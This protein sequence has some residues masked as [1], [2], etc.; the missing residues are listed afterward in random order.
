MIAL[1][2]YI[3]ISLIREGLHTT[4]RNRQVVVPEVEGRLSILRIRLDCLVFNRVL[5]VLCRARR[6]RRFQCRGNGIDKSNGGDP[7]ET[8]DNRRCSKRTFAAAVQLVPIPG[9]AIQVGRFVNIHNPGQNGNKHGSVQDS[10][11]YAETNRGQHNQAGYDS[12]TH[13][14][15]IAHAKDR[16]QECGNNRAGRNDTAM[17]SA[18]NIMTT[19]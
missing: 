5:T 17:V 15:R 1:Y 14:P 12:Q 11:R 6:S 8:G 10:L 3:D 16:R 7:Q 9:L 13:G 19:I 18:V 4:I 2:S